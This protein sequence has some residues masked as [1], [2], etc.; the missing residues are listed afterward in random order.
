[1]A[2][3]KYYHKSGTALKIA[4]V[5][6]ISNG[7]SINSSCKL[8]SRDVEDSTGSKRTVV[9]L[10][11]QGQ[12]AGICWRVTSKGRVSW[13]FHTCSTANGVSHYVHIHKPAFKVNPAFQLLPEAVTNYKNYI[14]TCSQ[15]ELCSLQAEQYTMI[16]S[17][18]SMTKY[19][20]KSVYVPWRVQWHEPIVLKPALALPLSST[21]G[22][23]HHAHG[24]VATH[25]FIL[26]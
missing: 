22:S 21:L 19:P 18:M 7:F 10:A 16:Q 8:S 12:R 25:V 6:W 26:A 2:G 24:T 5:C 4:R 13:P 11:E 9:C 1:M 17:T 23:L 14:P 15:S 20:S 3:V